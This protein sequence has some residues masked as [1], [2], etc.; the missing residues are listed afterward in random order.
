MAQPFVAIEARDLV[1]MTFKPTRW[2]AER[3]LGTGCYVVASKPKLGKSIAMLQLGAAVSAGQPFL[4][5]FET[6][7]SGVCA[8]VLE[9]GNERA[10]KRLWNIGDEFESGFR[11]VERAE[12]IDTGLF[13]QIE[14]DVIENPET[15]VYILD[16]L[17]A[18]RPPGAEYSFQTDYEITRTLADLA[19]RLGICIVLIHHC[20][21]S[22]GFGDAFDN[23]SGT[24]GLTAGATGMIVMADDPRNP[25]QVIMSIKGK[26]VESAAYRLEL[27]GAK[28]SLIAELSPHELRTN[29]IPEC[30]LAIIGWMKESSQISW[31]GSTTEL[32]EAARIERISRIALGKKLAQFSD[33]M[34][35]EGVHCRSNHTR[36]GTVV[37]L[38][39]AKDD[40]PD[41]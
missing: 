12:R 11:I 32:L 8:F 18:I 14:A 28:W 4:D 41:N 1:Q 16:T 9:D 23:I 5:H 21:K 2:F 31:S 3:L 20:R 6:M 39:V 35:S 13:E 38:E 33:Y 17:A 27:K 37:T 30:I 29:A 26:D 40:S 25:G 19:T 34:A 24:N 7:K 10:Q 15:G 36:K 22:V